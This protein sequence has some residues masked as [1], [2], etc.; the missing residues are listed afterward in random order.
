MDISTVLNSNRIN[1]KLDV[2]NKEEV[3]NSMVDMLFKEEVITSKEN[4]IKDVYFRETEGATGIGD[5]IAIPH[6]KSSS[7]LKTSLAVA[8]TIHPIE[9]ETLD[10]K[11]V[12]FIILFAVRDVDKTTVHVKLLG[13]IAE[14][15]ADENIVNQLLTSNDASEIITIFS[16]D[17]EEE[18]S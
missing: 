5:G 9:W 4:F 17:K 14:K 15:L 1:L 8:R 7:V 2:S 10:D 6:G 3:L 16:S 13:E 11:P 12:R 18:F